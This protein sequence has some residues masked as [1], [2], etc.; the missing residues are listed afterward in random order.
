MSYG[1]FMGSSMWPQRF[2]NEKSWSCQDAQNVCT[3]VSVPANHICNPIE[4]TVIITIYKN[5]LSRDIKQSYFSS[6]L[7][8]K[9]CAR[10]VRVFLQCTRNPIHKA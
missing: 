1:G 2:P 6:V 9:M 7:F 3:G 5:W 8:L 4:K 10:R